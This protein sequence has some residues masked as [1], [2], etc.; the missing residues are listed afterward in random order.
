MY[1]RILGKVFTWAKAHSYC[2]IEFVERGEHMWVFIRCW[3]SNQFR[4]VCVAILDRFS[5]NVK[6]EVVVLG[7]IIDA[8]GPDV[9]VV[10]VQGGPHALVYA[11]VN[12]LGSGYQQKLMDYPFWLALSQTL[13]STDC[14]K[15][16]W[17][18]GPLLH[19]RVHCEQAEGGRESWLDG[20]S[21]S[22]SKKAIISSSL[23]MSE[24]VDVVANIVG[25]WPLIFLFL[26]ETGRKMTTI[27]LWFDLPLS[28]VLHCFVR[29]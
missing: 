18:S 16:F 19:D 3:D 5:S 24:L 29:M 13:P 7:R 21:T 1:L 27:I 25:V 9:R 14:V 28:N 23:V 22:F 20:L 10:L 11:Y 26:K 15:C 2:G 6:E 17:N 4:R 8:I 12:F